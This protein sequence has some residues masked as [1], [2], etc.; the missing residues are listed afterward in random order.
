[1]DPGDFR[2]TRFFDLSQMPGSVR[3]NLGCRLQTN[4]LVGIITARSATNPQPPTR[5]LR[6]SSLAYP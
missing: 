2:L 1:M 3:A 4:A 6:T 5:A